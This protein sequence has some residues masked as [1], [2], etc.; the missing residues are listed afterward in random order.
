MVNSRM[1]I[2][3]IVLSA[4]LFLLGSC[5]REGIRPVYPIPQDSPYSLDDPPDVS[6]DVPAEDAS[7]DIAPSQDTHE[8]DGN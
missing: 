1:R 4:L 2:A 6:D 7:A 8:I 5:A 3:A